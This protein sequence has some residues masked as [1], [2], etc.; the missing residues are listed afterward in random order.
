[1]SKEMCVRL[2]PLNP[3]QGRTVANYTYKGQKYTGGQRPQWYICSEAMAQALAA[4]RMDSSNPTS[5]PIFQVVTPEEKAKIEQDEN[6]QFLAQIGVL[7][8]A[9]S[10]P[11]DIRNPSTHDL[12][13]PA[14]EPEAPVEAPEPAGRAAALPPPRQPTASV[15]E[16]GAVTTEDT[17]TGEVG[18][19]SSWDAD[20]DE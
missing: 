18:H 17:P 9:V 14:P 4:L 19:R 3:R 5:A 20:E 12:R 6:T 2:W 16:T 13:E 15:T 8:G 11:G 10:I 7:Q 1:M